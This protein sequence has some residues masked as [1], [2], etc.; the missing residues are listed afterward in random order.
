MLYELLELI[1][2]LAESGPAPCGAASSLVA[3][4]M[5]DGWKQTGNTVAPF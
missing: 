2:G 5:E 1:L 4:H 3:R